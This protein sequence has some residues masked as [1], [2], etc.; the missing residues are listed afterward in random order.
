MEFGKIIWLASYPKSG[1]TWVRFLIYN[2]VFG[3]PETITVKQWKIA[4]H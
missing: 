3:K 4:C 1:N 2:L